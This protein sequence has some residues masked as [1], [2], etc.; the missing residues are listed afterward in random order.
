[1]MNQK[2]ARMN[3]GKFRAFCFGQAGLDFGFSLYV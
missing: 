2:R 1:M 3:R